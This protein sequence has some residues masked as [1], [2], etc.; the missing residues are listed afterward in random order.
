MKTYIL[1]VHDDRYSVPTLDT[2]TVGDDARATEIAAR[3]L[4]SSPHYRAAEVWDD[5][6]LVCRIGRGDLDA[7]V[8]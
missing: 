4:A 6:R 8:G 2:V 5:E 3:R 7:P 1:Y